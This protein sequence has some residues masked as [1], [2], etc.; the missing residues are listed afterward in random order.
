MSHSQSQDGGSFYYY[1]HKQQPEH[2]QGSG[3]GQIP[4][5]V[6]SGASDAWGGR[7]P[8]DHVLGVGRTH[9]PEPPLSLW[10]YCALFHALPLWASYQ[11]WVVRS[12]EDKEMEG[13]WQSWDWSP[14]PHSSKA[15]AKV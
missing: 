1:Y 3:K 15:G 5:R 2:T 4:G 9:C 13:K 11:L 14:R 6:G 12:F 7:G 8:S 10:L